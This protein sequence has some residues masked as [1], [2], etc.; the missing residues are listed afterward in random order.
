MT[1]A[2]FCADIGT[3]SLKAAL[4]DYSG[5]VLCFTK[6][7][8]V[9]GLGTKR[10]ITALREASRE[11]VKNFLFDSKEVPHISAVSISGNGPSLANDA[12]QFLWNEPYEPDEPAAFIAKSAGQKSLFLPRILH[13]KHSMPEIWNQPGPVVSVPEYLV[14]QLTGEAATLLPDSRYSAAYWD[15]ELLCMFDIPKEKLPPFVDLGKPTGIL[16]KEEAELLDFTQTDMPPVFCGGPDFAIALIGTNTLVPGKICD[17]AGSSE[18]INLCTFDPLFAEGIR[19]LPSPV[20]P[21][22]NASV[23]IPDSG[24]RFAYWRLENLY[25]NIPE[26]ECVRYLLKN[27]DSDGYELLLRIAFEV[28]SNLYKLVS[29]ANKNGIS[30]YSYVTCTG[31]QA[32]SSAWL[33]M[34]ADILGLTLVQPA[35]PDAELTGNAAIALAGIGVFDTIP[36]AAAKMHKSQRDF[37]PSKSRQAMYQ[38]QFLK[39]AKKSEITK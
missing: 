29:F 9:S 14:M 39:L 25:G 31:G 30:P 21:L 34:K 5:N 13:V 35:S 2:V 32:H 23:L 26:D 18:G 22:W 7:R 38:E 24:E 10:W 1:E 16:L 15:E 11:F 27:T 33:Q 36:I 19:T 8:F 28:R 37:L 4:I 17:R 20:S 6:K 12:G 3:S